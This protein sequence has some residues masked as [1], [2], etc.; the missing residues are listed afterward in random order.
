M[1]N[2]YMLLL[3]VMIG[4]KLPDLI[5]YHFLAAVLCLA[6]WSSWAAMIWGII[7][8]L[9]IIPMANYNLTKLNRL[10]S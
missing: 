5:E 7:G 1:V 2:F 10:Q 3:E 8:S 9:F 6:V 4:V